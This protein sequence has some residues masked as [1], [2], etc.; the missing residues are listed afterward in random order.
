[1]YSDN[2]H[3]EQT[4]QRKE[5]KKKV[6]N[7]KHK[8]LYIVILA[9]ALAGCRQKGDIYFDPNDPI[10]M[11][12]TT[13]AKQFE[14]IWR[15]MNTQ[16][17]FW[18]EDQTDWD[19]VYNTMLPRFQELDTKYEADGSTP[20]SLTLVSMYAEATKSLIDHHLK[21]YVHDIHTGKECVYCP[22]LEEVKQRDYV[23]GQTYSYAAMKEAIDGFVKEGLLNEGTWGQI[24]DNLNFFGIRTV[25]DKKIA[26]LWQSSYNMNEALKK[27]GKTDQEKQYIQNIKSWLDMCLNEPNLLGIILDNRCNKGGN[28]SDLDIVIGSFIDERLHYADL[29]YKEGVGRYDYTNWIPAYVEVNTNVKPR[30]LGKANIPYVVL[31][32]AFSISMAETTAQIIKTLP[33][34]CMIGELTYGAHGQSNSYSTVFHDGAFGNPNGNHYVYTSNL[35]TRFVDEGILEGKGVTPT[36]SILQMESGYSGAMAKAIDYIKAY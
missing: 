33:T 17:V 25:D 1:M 10:N 30:D 12:Y 31:T 32:N 27:E 6:K 36:K 14:A 2:R 13:Y 28:V 21:L 16:Y 8:L 23:S 34:G 15:G 22:G 19:A 11:Q 7:M 26:Y 18:S 35:Q 24:G 20:D 5:T 3:T 29:R 9:S 4:G